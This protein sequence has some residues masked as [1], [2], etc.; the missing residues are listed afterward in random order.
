MLAIVIP[1]Y[2]I[3]FFKATLQSLALQT[4]KR[5]KVYIGN[6][7]SNEDPIQLLEQFQSQFDFEYQY[8][9]TNLGSISLTQQWERCLAMVGNE[10]WVMILG[11]DDT[12]DSS[13]VAI[14]YQNKD[15]VESENCKVIRYATQVIDHNNATLSEIYTHPEYETSTDFLMRKFK[16]GTRSSLSEFIF[17]KDALLKHKFKDLPLAWFSDILAVLEVSNFG[18]IY[19]INEAVVQFRLSGDNITSRADNLVLKNEATFE[20]FYYLIKEKK[21][22]F[23]DEE[24]TVLKHKLEKTFLDNKKK[25]RFWQ[26]FTTLYFK[27][28][29]IRDYGCFLFKYFNTLLNQIKKRFT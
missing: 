7:A 16:G 2:K 23:N 3:R 17:N 9:E 8:Y 15:Q 11:D 24:S 5:F 12:I 18:L 20:F 27:N 25:I 1:Y 28:F 19:T 4:D 26:L 6:D 22:F 10:Y 21:G 14:F 29:Y 13:C